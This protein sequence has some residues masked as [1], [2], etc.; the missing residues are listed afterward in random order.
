[1]AEQSIAAQGLSQGRPEGGAGKRRGL[2]GLA[3]PADLIA[4]L[5]FAFAV[6]LAAIFALP[7]FAYPDENFQL[8]EQGH[9]LAFG[10][11]VTPW[12]FETGIRSMVPPYILA[13]VFRIAEPIFGG[14]GGYIGVARILL[15]GL[16]LAPIAAIYEMGRRESKAH[17]ILGALVAAS[18]FEIVYFSFRPLTEAVSADFAMVALALASTEAEALSTRRLIAVGACLATALVLRIHLALGLAFVAA[19]TGRLQFRRRW[20]PMAL[21]GAPVVALF[22][23]VDWMTWGA[24]FASYVRGI[25]VNVIN[26]VANQ[27]GVLPWYWYALVIAA[28]WGLAM[29]VLFG[30]I[31]FRLRKSVAWIGF[32][33]I[34][35]V[36]H[37]LIAHK[38]YRFIFPA[39]ACFAVVAALGTADLIED[40]R[41]R[42]GGARMA[43]AVPAAALVWVAGSAALGAA[44]SFAPLWVKSRALI[45]AETRLA[46]TPGLC[47][48]ML[49]DELWQPTGGYAFLHRKAP[50][51]WL[52]KKGH[53]PLAADSD[54]AFN[55]AVGRASAL[56]DLAPRFAIKSCQD[57]ECIAER[58]GGCRR[59]AGLK[60][61]LEYHE[62]G[63]K[64]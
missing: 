30:L 1:M 15:A 34:V 19:W 16:S 4:I 47:G 40:I 38:E 59:I 6:R 41:R 54:E 11:G 43:M 5:I 39:T 58:P 18:W 53:G 52:I 36:S 64:N 63:L 57:G 56:R 37:S 49:Y 14:P 8:F 23:A 61:I 45:E 13:A 42:R 50:L 51:Y 10:Y 20:L 28:Y 29:P 62:L 26:G 3:A 27:F 60:P 32:A 2:A 7:S 24:P 46:D 44:P 17:A 48:V 9:R 22:G 55:A 31:G 25:Q 21:G 12:E 35:L 33:F